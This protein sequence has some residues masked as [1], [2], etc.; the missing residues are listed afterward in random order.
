MKSPFFLIVMK[1]ALF[2]G[3]FNPIHN[4]HLIIANYI[5]EHTTVDQLWMVV[6]PH[7]PL[8]KRA[9]LANDYDRLH[10]V[11]IATEQHDKIFSCDI[12]F[13]L[14]KPSYTIDTLVYLKEKYPDHEFEL[15]MGADNLVNFHKWKNYENILD[16]HRILVYGRPDYTPDQFVDH[17]SIKMIEAPLME[18]SSTVIRN[19][20]KQK[21]SFL[22]WVPLSVHDEILMS[23]LYQ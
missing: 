17:P 10:L 9:T 8:K 22:Y 23:G 11:N 16:A 20:I 19:L 12:E 14:P 21:K 4:G 7:N 15:V 18:I 3:S 6:S 2:F 5:V 1:V 13:N